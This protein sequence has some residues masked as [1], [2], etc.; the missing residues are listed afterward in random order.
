[1][2]HGMWFATA[3]RA[4]IRARTRV[5]RCEHF[6]LLQR[7]TQHA[8]TAAAAPAVV[9]PVN[10]SSRS[11]NFRGPYSQTRPLRSCRRRTKSWSYSRL[12]PLRLSQPPQALPHTTTLRIHWRWRARL[13]VALLVVAAAAAAAVAA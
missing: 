11:S 2:E 4:G 9:A 13:A 12:D 3:V 10:I 6:L 1:M 5:T 7:S 8:G